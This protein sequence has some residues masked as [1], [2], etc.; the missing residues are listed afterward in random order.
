MAAYTP[1][2]VVARV[3]FLL[4]APFSGRVMDRESYAWAAGF[5]DGEANFYSEAT[6]GHTRFII[7]IGQKDRD[8]LDRLVS[9]FPNSKI[10]G[11]YE[12]RGKYRFPKKS[13]PM[14]YK[15]SVQRF[16]HAQDVVAR[17][18]PWL[19]HVKREQ[20]RLAVRRLRSHRQ[21]EVCGID[22]SHVTGLDRRGNRFCR[23]CRSTKLRLSWNTR[24]G[25]IKCCV[26]A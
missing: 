5:F 3:R 20:I 10:T 14:Y 26:S 4:V 8:V 2:K 17:V 9:I 19:S 12:H 7:Q 16:E 1:R 23:D 24:R 18:W 6:T 22:S 21:N 11:P 15:W 25:G 13:I